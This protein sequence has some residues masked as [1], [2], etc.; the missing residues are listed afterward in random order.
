MTQATSPES[1]NPKYLESEEAFRYLIAF[2]YVLEMSDRLVAR[3]NGTG[4]KC[5]G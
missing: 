5:H 1:I 2:F 3:A 4:K